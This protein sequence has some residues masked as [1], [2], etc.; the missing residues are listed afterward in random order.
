MLP[1]FCD[2]ISFLALEYVMNKPVSV[3]NVNI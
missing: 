2:F 3:N 1:A